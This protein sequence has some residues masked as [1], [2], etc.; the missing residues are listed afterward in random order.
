MTISIVPP[1]Q[2]FSDQ[3]TA[4]SEEGVAVPPRILHTLSV[5]PMDLSFEVP[6]DL[7][8]GQ[9]D[10]SIQGPHGPLTVT[11]PE[12]AEPGDFATARL[13]PQS[14]YLVTLPAVCDSWDLQTHE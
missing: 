11:L 9:R 12:G 8:P 3:E 14:S 6:E 7:T 2:S 10:V 1:S 5:R 4:T 13:G